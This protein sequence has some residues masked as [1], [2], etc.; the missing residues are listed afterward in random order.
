M[1]QTKL[2]ATKTWLV[3]C[4]PQSLVGAVNYHMH[5]EKLD[6]WGGPFNGQCFRQTMYID[7]VRACKFTAVV[8]TGTFRG[9]TTVFLALNSGGVPVHTSENARV[10]ELA[11]RRLRR[12]SH[13]HLYNTDSRKMLSTINL[14]EAGC[15]FFYLDA[16]WMEDLPLAEETDMIAKKLRSFVIMIDDFAVP[17]DPGYSYD[18]YGPGKGLC[19]RDFPFNSDQRFVSYFPARA[20]GEES[21]IRRGSI[22]LASR[23]MKEKLD[24]LPSLR[25]SVTA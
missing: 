23:D 11:K 15:T 10:F 2:N 25:P 14:P 24:S 13:V 7:L 16:H 4:L 20:S 17:N 5:P 1:T 6:S 21:G 3:N 22:V 8:E 12:F 18:D 9:S 19:L